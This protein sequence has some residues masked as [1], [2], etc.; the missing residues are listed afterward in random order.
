MRASIPHELDS[1]ADRGIEGKGD[2]T[3]DTLCR[4]NNDGVRSPVPAVPAAEVTDGGVYVDGGGAKLA[5]HCD[6]QLL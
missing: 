6:T 4:S 3:K 5:M 2:I 1:V